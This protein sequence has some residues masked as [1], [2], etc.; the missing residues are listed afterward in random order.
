MD[1]RYYYENAAA[2]YRARGFGALLC[3]LAIPAAGA[4]AV[5]AAT[6][7]WSTLG[8]PNLTTCL[9]AAG[10]ACVMWKPALGVIRWI[11]GIGPSA[12]R[13]LGRSALRT[14]ATATACMA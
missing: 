13:S 14:R 4:E 2:P 6:Q 11:E 12:A 1:Y 9:L 10:S 8:T 3:K 5:L 7:A